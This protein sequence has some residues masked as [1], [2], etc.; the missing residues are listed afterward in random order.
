[1][2]DLVVRG[3][4]VVDGTGGPVRTADVAVEDGLIVEVGEV[5]ARARRTID[6]DGAVVTPGFVDIHTHYDGQATWDAH[7]TPSCWHGV[8]TAILGNCGVGFAP[9]APDG[10]QRLIDLMEGVE[11]IP[12]SALAEGIQWGWES[13]PDYLD[14]LDRLPRAIDVGTHLPHAAV[15]AYVMGQRLHEPAHPDDLLAMAT[16]VREAL[17]AGAL[18]VST[19]RTAGHRDIHGDL[20]PGT[21]ADDQEVAALLQAMVDVGAGVLQVVPAGISDE[22]GGDQPGAM[23]RELAWLVAHGRRFD[24]PITFLAMQRGEDTDG[25]RPWFQEVAEANAAGA[26]I[27]PQV[28]N[29]C[30]GV[31]MGHQSRMNPFQYFPTYRG[32]MDLPFGER[33]RRLG[34]PDIRATILGEERTLPAE[35]SMDVLGRR[36]FENLFPLG[37]PLD[38]EPAPEASVASIARRTGQDPWAVAYDLLLESEGREFL[39]FPLLNF[40]EGSYDGLHDMMT[41]PMTVQGLGDGGA[42]CGLVCDASMTTYMVSHWA[43]DRSRGAKFTLEW[44]VKRLTGDP[45]ALYGLHDRGLL[46]PGRRADLNLIDFDELGLLH[47]ERVDDLPGGAGRLIQRSTGYLETI[48]AGETVV[49]HGELTDARPGGLVRGGQRSMSQRRR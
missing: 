19:G 1:M 21:L 31:L 17:R 4:I 44:A 25:W 12:G 20:V 24:R 37:D 49:D 39:L 8:T 43:R 41:S 38:Y 35:V 3:G 16:I 42:H 2:H 14:A 30:F 36:S 48:V 22:M 11:D 29:R 10:Q 45:S 7:L 6:A 5:D 27:H 40:G 15:R 34:D 13:F 18:G 28:A 9:V 46:T 32:L 47:P 23:E 26:R 33:I